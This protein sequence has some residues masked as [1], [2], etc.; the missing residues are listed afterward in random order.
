M[1]DVSIGTLSPGPGPAGLGQPHRPN[2]DHDNGPLAKIIFAVLLFGGV[3]FTAYSLWRDIGSTGSAVRC[4]TS[5]CSAV[6]LTRR[7]SAC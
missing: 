5:S 7:A 6:G 4:T 2:L 1:S 3:L